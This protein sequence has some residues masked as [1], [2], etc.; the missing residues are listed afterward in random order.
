MQIGPVNLTVSFAPA[1]VSTVLEDKLG[2]EPCRTENNEIA[3]PLRAYAILDDIVELGC[4]QGSIR[5]RISLGSM[6]RAVQSFGK[7]AKSEP[8]QSNV[9]ALM[10]FELWASSIPRLP[11]GNSWRQW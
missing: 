6:R 8:C 4:W 9:L 10:S 5:A 3:R 7:A 11:Q 1:I 2:G